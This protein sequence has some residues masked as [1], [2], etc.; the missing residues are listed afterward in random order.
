MGL[1]ITKPTLATFQSWTYE[2]LQQHQVWQRESW[3]DAEFFDGV[4]WN[5]LDASTLRNKKGINPL[6]INRVFPIINLVYG[7]YIR[8][9]KDIVAKGR[10]KHDSELSQVISEAIAMVVDQNGGTALQREAFQNAIVPGFG[11]IYTGFN[12]DPRKENILLRK[13]PWHSV[14]WDPYAD[15]WFN[16][17]NCR[18]VLTSAWKDIEDLK[19]LFPD[20]A[21]DIDD[22]CAEMLPDS[23]VSTFYTSSAEDIGTEIENY[24]NF[25][26]AGTWV[27][28][29]RKRVRPV[30]MWYTQVQPTWFAILPD[31]RVFELDK[32]PMNVQFNMVQAAKEVVQANV[33]QMF[34]ATFI[35]NLLLQNT[36]SPFPHSEYPFTSFIGYLDRFGF[37]YGLPRQIREQNMEVNKRRSMALALI[38]SR[39]TVAERGAAEDMNTLHDEANRLDG[40]LVV[41]PG[42]INAVNIEELSQL[43][44]PQIEMMRQSEQ[45]M[46]EIIGANDEALG[47]NTPAQSGVSLEKKREFSGTMTLS[48]MENVYRSQKQL[49]E[50]IL[51]LIQNTWTSAKVLRVIDRLSG[52]E[53]FVEVNQQVQNQ[54][55]QI[56][57]KNDITQARF[58]LVITTKEISDTMREKNLDLLFSAIN[59]APAE[60]VAPLLNVA[61]ELSDIPEK[62]R[63]LAKIRLATGQVGEDEDLTTEERKERLIAAKQ[64]QDTLQAQQQANAQKREELEHEKLA[65]DVLAKK[66]EGEAKL[67]TA[68]AA[69]QTAEQDGFAKGHEIA[70]K[71]LGGGTN[72]TSTG[73]GVRSEGGKVLPLASRTPKRA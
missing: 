12:S 48:L 13:L 49:G 1:N 19:I 35:G 52:V 23:G 62:E 5:E 27:N 69:M 56:E 31:D 59:K 14:L 57:V 25:L 38:S 61:F 66:A 40:F 55:G 33:K 24:K 39:R 21:K 71:M 53:K 26:A 30:E 54:F 9:Q 46:K 44:A 18:Y 7:N 32:F 47:Y 28:N 8:N 63:I 11:C 65:A 58:D 50:K 36:K 2:A 15:P 37:P 20:Q 45:E 67:I 51:S 34:T 4:Q 72:D 73:S 22:A 3:Q 64:Q 43:A 17:D 6:T 16:T 68:H 41:E 10:T 29:E 42:K 70:A 60:A